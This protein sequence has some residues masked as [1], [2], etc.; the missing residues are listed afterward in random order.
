MDALEVVSLE[1]RKL[2]NIVTT[3]VS[4]RRI[5]ESRRPIIEEF[6]MTQNISNED[7]R[8]CNDY[9]VY[10]DIIHQIATCFQEVKIDVVQVSDKINMSL[11]LMSFEIKFLEDTIPKNKDLVLKE[12]K[13]LLQSLIQTKDVNTFQTGNHLRHMLKAHTWKLEMQGIVLESIASL[14]GTR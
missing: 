4:L 9:W 11:E 6:Q 8:F 7:A 1:E 13:N 2:K 10:L 5:L 3:R 14:Q 12:A